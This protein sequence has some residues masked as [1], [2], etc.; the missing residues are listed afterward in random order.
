M[1]NVG[2]RYLAA[3]LALMFLAVLVFLP[4]GA[5]PGALPREMGFF[6][7]L[8]NSLC[9]LDRAKWQWMEERRK[10][11]G[12]VPTM[13]DLAPYLGESTNRIAQFIALGISYNI[14]PIS[15]MK[16]Q[17]DTATLTR[18]VSFQ[19]GFCRFYLAGTRYS[20][21]GDSFYPPYDTKSRCIGLYQNNRG[22]LV[23]LLFAL[24]IGNL[25]VFVIKRSGMKTGDK[26]YT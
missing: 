22:L 24:A 14:S 12:D 5:G 3:A 17:S 6:G 26:R 20:L 18:D 25:M 7:G 1:R 13:S 10:A 23:I 21:Q 11:Q 4:S 2:Y 15:E 16:P 8:H 19:R 9:D